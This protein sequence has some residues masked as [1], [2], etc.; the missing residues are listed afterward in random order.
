MAFL[1]LSSSI[2]VL[3]LLLFRIGVQ[4]LFDAGVGLYVGGFGGSLGFFSG[5]VF[6]QAFLRR[7]VPEDFSMEY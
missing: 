5:G 3:F 1:R 4:V 7:F 2:G 6:F